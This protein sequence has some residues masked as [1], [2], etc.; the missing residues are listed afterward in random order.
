VPVRIFGFS[1]LDGGPWGAAW[2]PPTLDQARLLGSAV[3]SSPPKIQ[4]EGEQDS[5][6]W[7]LSTGATDLTVDGLGEAVWSDPGTEASG[8][9]QLCQVT[10]VLAGK[11]GHRDVRSL[12][13]RSCRPHPLSPSR[14]ESLRLVA[15]W[16][17]PEEGFAVLAVRPKGGRGQERDQIKAALFSQAGAKPATDPRLSTTYLGT[18][19]AARASVELWVETEADSETQYPRRAIGEALAPPAQSISGELGLEARPFRWY[20]AGREGAGIYL[21]GRAA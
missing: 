21:L 16:F 11:S 14:V 19:P 10:G 15:A 18:E 12:G 6:P 20:S 2:I 9:D 8:F 13:W 1:D 3:E 5:E 4:L 17:D 7:R